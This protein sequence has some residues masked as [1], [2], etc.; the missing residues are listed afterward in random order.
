M[1]YLGPLEGQLTQSQ[2]ENVNLRRQREEHL[3]VYD[4]LAVA[5]Q[6]RDRTVADHRALLDTMN[7]AILGSQ[8]STVIPNPTPN[9]TSG[10]ASPVGSTSASAVRTTG[11]RVRK[12]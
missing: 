7:S 10:D 4:L 12:T 2:V 3:A 6:D 8:S 11:S 9:P 1:E 5:E